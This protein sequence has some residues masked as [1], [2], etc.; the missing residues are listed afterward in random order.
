M[1]KL[2]VTTWSRFDVTGLSIAPSLAGASHSFVFEGREVEIRLPKR[3][4]R[5]RGS[6]SSWGNNEIYCRVWRSKTGRPVVY[7]VGSVDVTVKLANQ[8]NVRNRA[9]GRVDTSLFTKQTRQRLDKLVRMG[10]GIASRA[11][12]RWL[13]TL[14]WK[15]LN[16]EIGQDEIV[17]SVTR[18]TYLLDA[19]TG[20]RFYTSVKTWTLSGTHPV[21]RRVWKLVDESM[22]HQLATPV[23][24]TFLF[25]GQ[26]RVAAGDLHA[27][28]LSLAIAVESVLR[29][30][31]RRHL[32]EPINQQFLSQVDQISI[33]RFIDS[34]QK[35][36]F[37]TPRWRRAFDTAKIKRLFRLRNGIIHRGDL[38]LDSAECKEIGAS[39]SALIVFAATRVA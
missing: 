13:G 34:W 33:G 7:D 32:K 22:H 8:V 15:S 20:S 12:E 36:G 24:F 19:L 4:Q 25:D 18:S 1:K 9:L 11:L 28:I 17:P 2:K 10:E 21:S 3:P 30:V 38:E 6:S 14:R 37:A 5:P 39:V 23:W 35:L 31:L 27:G 26:H 29:V 16:F